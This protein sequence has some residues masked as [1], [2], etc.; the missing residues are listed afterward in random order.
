MISKREISL[1]QRISISHN[2]DLGFGAGAR[3]GAEATLN[4]WLR[5]LLFGLFH[6]HLDEGFAEF[7]VRNLVTGSLIW[8]LLFFMKKLSSF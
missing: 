3:A 1:L 2:R 4:M 7:N 8:V 5:L 6:S